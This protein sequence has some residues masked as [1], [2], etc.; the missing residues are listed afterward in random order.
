[1]D[2]IFR[3]EEKFFR[4][5][6]GYN[7][8]EEGELVSSTIK[9]IVSKYTIQPEIYICSEP[10]NRELYVTEYQDDTNRESGVIFEEIVKALNI[11]KC[12]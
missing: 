2:A 12:D 9:D 5:A 4:L 6:I 1:M 8:K 7:T 11:T 10:N 3:S